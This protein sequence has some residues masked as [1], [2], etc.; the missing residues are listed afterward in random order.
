MSLVQRLPP[1]RPWRHAIWCVGWHAWGWR[2]GL[3]RWYDEE[4]RDAFKVFDVDVE[5]DIQWTRRLRQVHSAMRSEV[6]S[7]A[8]MTWRAP[9][10]A[11][12][13]IWCKNRSHT[14]ASFSHVWFQISVDIFFQVSTRLSLHHLNHVMG[15]ADMLL[16]FRLH[17]RNMWPVCVCIFWLGPHTGMLY[18]SIIPIGRKAFWIGVSCR[19]VISFEF[20]IFSRASIYYAICINKHKLCFF[21]HSDPI[22]LFLHHMMVNEK[23]D[24]ELKLYGCEMEGD[25]YIWAL[26][27]VRST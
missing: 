12:R 17:L 19:L 8:K 26:N 23:V 9:W 27:F 4:I 22:S 10:K 18:L 7:A 21:L 16:S 1:S 2:G 5:H 25:L 11:H 14:S 24:A 6:P 3:W 20:H 13:P 15:A